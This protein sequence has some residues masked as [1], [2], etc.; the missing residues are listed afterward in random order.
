MV[1]RLPGKTPRWRGQRV[2]PQ[3]LETEAEWCQDVGRGHRGESSEGK[4]H[5]LLLRPRARLLPAP[6]SSTRHPFLQQILSC[7]TRRSGSVSVA[8][9][10]KNLKERKGPS[11]TLTLQGWK[12]RPERSR[13]LSRSHRGQMAG[14]SEPR[15]PGTAPHVGLSTLPQP[16]HQACR[17]CWRKG[18]PSRLRQDGEKTETGGGLSSL[19]R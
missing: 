19:S 4:P 3:D 8:C 1:T 2:C 14:L 15:L 13:D 9:R 12:L 16:P 5:L 7:W 11:H 18:G 17:G 10:P 6:P